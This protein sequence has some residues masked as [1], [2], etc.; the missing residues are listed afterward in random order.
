M[1][2]PGAGIEYYW[3]QKNQ[4]KKAQEKKSQPGKDAVNYSD[5]SQQ[6]GYIIFF[7]LL[8]LLITIFFKEKV[9]YYFLLLILAGMVVLNADKVTSLLSRFSPK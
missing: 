2:L 9:L 3:L 7:I 4:E 8:A 1:L 6:F 5:F